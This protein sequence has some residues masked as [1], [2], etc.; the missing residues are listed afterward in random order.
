MGFDTLI[1]IG[2]ESAAA[3]NWK[4][5]KG[6]KGILEGE[7]LG[8]L[9]LLFDGCETFAQRCETFAQRPRR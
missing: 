2:G 4:A 8:S 6:S 9:L 7:G 3:E 5:P 1:A